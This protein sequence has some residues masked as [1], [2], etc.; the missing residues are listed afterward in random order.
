MVLLE[1]LNEDY[2]YAIRHATCE[3]KLL[4]R[5]SKHVAYR[6]ASS[7]ATSQDIKQ[8]TKAKHFIFTDDELAYQYIKCKDTESKHSTV[9]L[10]MGLSE[11]LYE[12]DNKI[13]Q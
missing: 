7:Q 10:Y 5:T 4:S 12:N 6:Y 3:T 1:I 11:V 13:P 8:L 2:D 9:S